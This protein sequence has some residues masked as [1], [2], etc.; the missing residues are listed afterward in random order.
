MNKQANKLMNKTST[1][2]Q[3]K[4]SNKLNELMNEQT[5]E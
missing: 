1:I 3:P 5:N 4:K 2:E